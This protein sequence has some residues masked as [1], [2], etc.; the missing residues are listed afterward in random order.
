MMRAAD[1]APIRRTLV[2]LAWVL[3]MTFFFAKI[4]V[5]IEGL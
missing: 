5:Q 3:V 1:R 2:Y 4:E